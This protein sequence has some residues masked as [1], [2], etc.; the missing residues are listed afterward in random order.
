MRRIYKLSDRIRIK[1]GD[2]TVILRPL[3]YKEKADIQS[4]MITSSGNIRGAMDAAVN[5]LKCALVGF[6]GISNADGSPYV[7]SEADFDDVLN[8]P[9]SSTLTKAAMNLLN[10]IPKEFVDPHTA[11][12]LQGV[13]FLDE[14]NEEKK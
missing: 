10:N 3:T 14:V 13:E 9:E 4:E 5:A 7:Y 2:L 1:V 8:M 11:Q 6:E 12:K